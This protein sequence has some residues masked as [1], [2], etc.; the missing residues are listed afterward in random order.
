[1]ECHEWIL[2]GQYRNDE[3]CSVMRGD[4]GGNIGVMCHVEEATGRGRAS[5]DPLALSQCGPDLMRCHNDKVVS[6]RGGGTVVSVRT[7]QWLV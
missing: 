3:K 1:M 2:G 5:S 4:K 6:V 7:V